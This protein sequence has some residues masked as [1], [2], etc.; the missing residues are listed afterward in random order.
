[1]LFYA[2]SGI[3]LNSG[4]RSIAQNI[5]FFRFSRRNPVVYNA[6][7]PPVPRSKIK[8][9]FTIIIQNNEPLDLKSEIIPIVEEL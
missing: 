1:M 8:I 4:I 5:P 3:I 9:L 6:Y 7:D 2:S